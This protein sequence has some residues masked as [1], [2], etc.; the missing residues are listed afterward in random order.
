M[1]YETPK[2]TISTFSS[3][4]GHKSVVLLSAIGCGPVGEKSHELIEPFLSCPHL[5]EALPKSSEDDLKKSLSKETQSIPDSSSPPVT[6][7]QEISRIPIKDI[8]R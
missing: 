7:L 3:K 2:S 4:Y 8:F 5:R 6:I 1:K